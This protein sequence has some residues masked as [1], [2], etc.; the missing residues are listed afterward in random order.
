MVRP[1]QTLAAIW[2]EG[3][4]A[5]DD[6]FWMTTRTEKS[7]TTIVDIFPDTRAATGLTVRVTHRDPSWP[8]PVI[9]FAASRANLRA[10]AQ[11]I[12]RRLRENPEQGP[13]T[14]PKQRNYDYAEEERYRRAR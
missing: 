3:C 8:F 12:L 10:F 7:V 6:P 14:A 13:G 11:F 2:G 1:R 5:P 4:R 9:E